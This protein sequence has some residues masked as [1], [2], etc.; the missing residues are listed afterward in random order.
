MVVTYASPFSEDAGV[1]NGHRFVPAHPPPALSEMIKNTE[2]WKHFFVSR[3][4]MGAPFTEE[5]KILYLAGAYTW[6]RK[7]VGIGAILRADLYRASQVFHHAGCMDGDS[8]LRLIHE[9]AYVFVDEHYRENGRGVGIVE[10]LL[11]KEGNHPVYATVDEKNDSMRAVL[12]YCGFK[13]RGK[14]FA[15]NH[16][17]G[18]KLCLYTKNL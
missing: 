10:N 8:L 6:D 5:D 9:L 15:S 12:N 3:F 16:V 13:R 18:R 17:D 4:T 14:P 7:A 2:R 1:W 11:E